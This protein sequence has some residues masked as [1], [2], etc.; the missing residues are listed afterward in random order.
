MPERPLEGVRIIDM[1]AFWSGPFGACMLA[2]LGA[3]VIKLEATK[4][5]DGW[6]GAGVA[7]LPEEL[8]WERSPLFNSVNTDKLGITLDLSRPKGVDIYKRLVKISDV[9]MENFTPRVM[10]NFGLYY[11]VLKGIKPDIIM[12]SMPAHG[13]TGPW[14]EKPG[15]AYPIEQMSGIPQLTG[16]PDGPPRMTETSPSD[17]A[18][19]VNGAIA[20]LTALVYHQ[21]TGKGQWI[22]LSQ[23]EALPCCVGDAIVEYM[24]NGTVRP[25]YGNHHPYFA[26]QGFY[27]CK[28]DDRWAGI[29]I[30]TDEEWQGFVR[31][32]GSPDWATSE[33][34]A[35]A[36]G[37]WH[38]QDEMDRF[39][40]KWTE[41]HDHYEVMDILQKA[42]VAAG[43]VMTGPEYL[44]DPHV[45]A[46]GD[47]Q[48][49]ER[50]VTGKNRLPVMSASM[51]FSKGP[52]PIR[53][54]A[55]LLGEHNEYVF[56]E[57]LGMSAKEIQALY[58]EG[59][60]GKMPTAGLLTKI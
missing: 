56:G 58:D 30:R 8:I 24:M 21:R 35:T 13:S 7:T 12:V 1:T 11:D 28:G 26:P 32:L 25:R 22:D 57:L 23:I 51:R 50:N 46:R 49:V 55:P 33:K 60:T 5:M 37:R 52:F 39:I 34:Y 47:Y 43:P 17:P 3:E 29:T 54:S 38:H 18:A 2:N 9:V 14:S 4:R 36:T 45:N 41:E 16:S 42:G 59:I 20:V 40:E 48:E 31:A 53:H 19:G 6:R 44:S 10:K 27:R 15:F